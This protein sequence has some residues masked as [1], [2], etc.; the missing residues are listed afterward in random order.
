MLDYY[1][2]WD[3]RRVKPSLH[4]SAYKWYPFNQEIEYDLNGDGKPDKIIIT[5]S[6]SGVMLKINDVEMDCLYSSENTVDG[7][8]IINI[9]YADNYK[10]IVIS[11]TG[12]SSDF[13]SRFY[14]YDGKK[15]I[16]M[17]EGASISRPVPEDAKE[18]VVSD[19]IEGLFTN[20]E[21]GN[22]GITTL[23][24]ATTLQTWWYP[25]RYEL[26]DGHLLQAVAEIFE[27]DYEVF[28][29]SDM[30]LYSEKSETSSTIDMRKGTLA[31]ITALDDIE[32]IQ[33]RLDDGQKG[34]FKIKSHDVI[35]VK[36]NEIKAS[37]VFFYLYSAD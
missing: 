32:W 27:V 7:F 22:G 33:I 35:V 6:D 28:V 13:T 24:R 17:N 5:L 19:K 12:Y 3:S 2:D 36:D 18:W 4:S 11:D 37:D 23:Q 1:L 25:L 29:L 20:M 26:T 16:Y 9:D 31:K 8:A 34:W 10:E 14:G 15:I 21:I 30:P